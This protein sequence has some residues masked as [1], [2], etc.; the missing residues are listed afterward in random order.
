[1]SILFPFSLLETSLKMS[2]NS[3]V[4]LVNCSLSVVYLFMFFAY[5]YRYLYL[6]YQELPLCLVTLTLSL[7]LVITHLGKSKKK[8]KL[9]IC[10]RNRVDY[11]SP[12][13]I[14][15]HQGFSHRVEMDIQFLAPVP[16]IFSSSWK[17]IPAMQD[18]IGRQLISQ[19]HNPLEHS[20]FQTVLFIFQ[21]CLKL[22]P[23]PYLYL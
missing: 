20:L 8:K 12:Q 10:S 17:S 9:S 19:S 2:I 18:N 7:K 6:Q 1:M 22:L 4:L 21:L 11:G 5:I 23:L 3:L 13:I 16:F 14:F 15:C